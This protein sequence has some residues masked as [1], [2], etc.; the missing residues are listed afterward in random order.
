[1]QLKAT[2]LVLYAV[3]F[4]IVL[5]C[6]RQREQQKSRF[7]DVDGGPPPDREECKEQ[8]LD[9]ADKCY[10]REASVTCIGCCRDQDTL[11][12]MQQ[13]YSFA[14]CETAP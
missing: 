5:C 9:C 13:K 12:L 1:M 7:A 6:C 8:A 3:S 2:H 11:C 10:K 4:A 14:Y